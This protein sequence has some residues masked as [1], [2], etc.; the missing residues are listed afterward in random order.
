MGLLKTTRSAT[1]LDIAAKRYGN[2]ARYFAGIN[3]SD[4]KSKSL[5]NVLALRFL[6]LGR[7]RVLFYTKRDIEAGETM[8]FDYN[9][10]KVFE[11]YPT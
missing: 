3:N 11:E 2:M 4:P 10:G 6:Y 5:E 9:G 1:S 8:Y 7:V